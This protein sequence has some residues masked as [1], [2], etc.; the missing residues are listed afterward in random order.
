MKSGSQQ[1][2]SASCQGTGKMGLF[3]ERFAWHCNCEPPGCW[4]FVWGALA[5]L[6]AL[7]ATRTGSHLYMTYCRPVLSSGMLV[8]L[9]AMNDGH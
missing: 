1:L 4:P 7:A 3:P 9:M 5:A 2:P 8:S 6:A